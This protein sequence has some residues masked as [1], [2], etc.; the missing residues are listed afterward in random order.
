MR[1]ILV[2]IFFKPY[3]NT[4]I[5]VNNLNIN[6]CCDKFNRNN[7]NIL[8]KKLGIKLSHKYCYMDECVINL[9]LTVQVSIMM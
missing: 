3:N 5:Y 8:K 7:N 1:I 4:N 9:I 2:Y 6:D